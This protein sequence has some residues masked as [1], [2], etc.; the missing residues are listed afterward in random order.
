MVSG[1]PVLTTKLSGIPDEY[2]DYCFTA[3]VFSA[4]NIGKKITE[5]LAMPEDELKAFG[6]KARQFV[7]N[8]KNSYV[9]SGKILQ[10]IKRSVNHELET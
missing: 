10:F 5:I 7:L 9:Q 2:F 3:D 4:N 1:T 6:I 8:N